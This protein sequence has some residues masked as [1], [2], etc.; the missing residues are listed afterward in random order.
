MKVINRVLLVVTSAL[1]LTLIVDGIL[2]RIS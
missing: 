1:I 2:G